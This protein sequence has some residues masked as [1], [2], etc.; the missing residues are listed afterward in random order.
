MFSPYH[1]D[2]PAVD[3]ERTLRIAMA[4]VRG[5]ERS[6]RLRAIH[7]KRPT[8]VSA[9]QTTERAQIEGTTASMSAPS[10]T[11]PHT[12]TV[13]KSSFLLCVQFG[14]GFHFITSHDI[15]D[16]KTYAD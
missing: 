14:L 13:T 12:F 10:R 15:P 16:C 4:R 9:V 7:E 1:S 5:E 2:A 8:S 11:P 6:N 3:E